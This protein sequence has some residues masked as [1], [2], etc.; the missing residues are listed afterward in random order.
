MRRRIKSDPTI[1]E[2]MQHGI[3][4]AKSGVPQ[5]KARE[6]A[7]EHTSRQARAA[8]LVAS[9]RQLGAA[10]AEAHRDARNARAKAL[11]FVDLA[12]YL[13]RRYVEDGAR[14]EDLQRE[15]GA[16]YEAVRAELRRAGI[17]VR[18]GKRP[19]ARR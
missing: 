15:L 13:H 18:R 1:Q 16:S 17:N 14:L 2:G 7:P 4:L 6:A 9:G 12:D 10:R 5:A 19:S 3:A 8:Q 11:G